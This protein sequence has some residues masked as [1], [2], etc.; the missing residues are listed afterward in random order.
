MPL[1]TGVGV[2]T[3][4]RA[5]GG[6]GGSSEVGSAPNC[7]T[8][9]G[10]TPLAVECHPERSRENASPGVYGKGR[11][12]PQPRTSICIFPRP[13]GPAADPPFLWD[14]VGRPGTPRHRALRLQLL[15]PA[16]RWSISWVFVLSMGCACCHGRSV[17][18]PGGTRG[19]IAGG[20][21]GAHHG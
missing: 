7:P 15:F 2:C 12:L 5:G 17:L 16:P 19:A 13:P 8:A 14:R 18:A 20:R 21:G 6:Y 1:N 4:R 11:H 9:L 10:M 3:V